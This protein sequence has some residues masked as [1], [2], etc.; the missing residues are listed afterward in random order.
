M[1]KKLLSKDKFLFIQRKMFIL[2]IMYLF[3]LIIVL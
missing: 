1:I 2:H 3:I